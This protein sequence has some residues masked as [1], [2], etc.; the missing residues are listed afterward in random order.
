MSDPL[1]LITHLPHHHHDDGATHVSLR[2]DRHTL[3][4][5]RWRGRAADG[6]EFGFDLDAPLAH[7]ACF[8][9]DDK[10]RYL[11]EQLPEPVLEIAIAT[12]EDAARLGWQIGNLHL[13]V[14]VLP[15]ALRVADD[16]AAAQLLAR[17][18]IAFQRRVAVFQPLGRGGAPHP[19]HH[20]HE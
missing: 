10:T 3:A 9:I 12:P 14:Q 6:R 20:A 7:D 4:K 15:A 17:E 18:N 1:T 2:A 13:V 11:I 5:R 8:F 19:H 16:P